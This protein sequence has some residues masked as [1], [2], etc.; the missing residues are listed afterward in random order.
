MDRLPNNTTATSGSYNIVE[1]DEES[2]NIFKLTTDQFEFLDLVANTVHSAAMLRNSNM[3]P[4]QM[5][6]TESNNTDIWKLR[7]EDAKVIQQLSTDCLQ[8]DLVKSKRQPVLHLRVAKRLNHNAKFA[9]LGLSEVLAKALRAAAMRRSLNHDVILV[10]FP[11]RITPDVIGE[12]PFG[13]VAITDH[14]TA[15]FR[16]PT[17]VELV[18]DLQQTSTDCVQTADIVILDI[19]NAVPPAVICL[20]Q[21]N[22]DIIVIDEINV[23]DDRPEAKTAVRRRRPT[24]SALGRRLLKVGRMLCCWCSVVPSKDTK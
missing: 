6:V 11:R 17:T 2:Q 1:T 9:T 19:Q 16:Q 12:S 4:R 21:T 3:T 23:E 7:G 10:H 15:V 18:S 13:N 8:S 20:R 22:D 24:L 5:S 14:S